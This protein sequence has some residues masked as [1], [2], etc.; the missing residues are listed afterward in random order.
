MAEKCAIVC[1]GSEPKSVYPPFILGS[2]AAALGYEVVMFFVPAGGKVLRKGF[3]ENMKLENMPELPGL[4]DAIMEM[5]GRILLCE[6]ALKVVPD[7]T[8]EDL[9]DGAEVV[10]AA[11][12]F[13]AIE[14]ANL[15]FSF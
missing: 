11:T 8:K 13:G 4:L 14:G 6:L 5:G 15:T 7:L 2:T 12:F 10:D 1:N 9:I 3:L